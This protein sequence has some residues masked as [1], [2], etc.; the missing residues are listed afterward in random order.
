MIVDF[1]V[2]TIRSFVGG[3]EELRSS[4]SYVVVVVYVIAYR[5]VIVLLLH[6]FVRFCGSIRS[7][8]LRAHTVIQP[9]IA[10][11]VT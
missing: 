3:V 10:G 2:L 4:S 7:F 6:C 11:S 1:S 8:T 9:D 5:M